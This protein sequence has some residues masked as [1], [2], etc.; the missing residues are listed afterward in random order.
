MQEEKNRMC[1]FRLILM[2]TTNNGRKSVSEEVQKTI[3]M[4]INYETGKGGKRERGRA[5]TFQYNI[6]FFVNFCNYL[7]QIIL[8]YK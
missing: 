7:I 2:E 8:N 6:Q 1:K 4:C 3:K 5:Y